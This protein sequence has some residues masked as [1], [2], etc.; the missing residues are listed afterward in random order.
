MTADAS[1]SSGLFRWRGPGRRSFPESSVAGDERLQ[2]VRDQLLCIDG[3]AIR[4]RV[5]GGVA[6]EVCLQ[7]DRAGEGQLD[8]LSLGQRPKPPLLGDRKSVVEGTRVSV[9]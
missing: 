8:V 5:Q 2:H 9:R 3:L 1:A 4:L 6:V 7:V